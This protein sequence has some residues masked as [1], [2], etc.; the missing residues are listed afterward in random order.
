VNVP[1]RRA[2][3]DLDEVGEKRLS[4]ISA[5]EFLQALEQ[6]EA[7]GAEVSPEDVTVKDALAGARAAFRLPGGGLPEKKKLELEKPAI[8]KLHEGFPEKK[9]VEL[10]K[11]PIEKPQ[12]EKLYEGFPEKKK[13]ELEK[14]PFE[15][16]I[17]AV[18]VAEQLGER[19]TRIEEQL[20]RL[21]Q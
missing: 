20:A 15:R 21:T 16:P 1:P 17:E 4:E 6:A 5:A 11:L 3:I 8:E 10:E 14:P 7:L 12:I 2:A 13:V 19:L 9:K 18:G